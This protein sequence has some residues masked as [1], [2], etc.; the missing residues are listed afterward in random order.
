M[1]AKHTPAPWV[2][3]FRESHWSVWGDG[4]LIGTVATDDDV[5][6]VLAAPQLLEALENLSNAVTAARKAED[7][8]TKACNGEPDEAWHVAAAA[9]EDAEATVVICQNAALALLRAARG[10]EAN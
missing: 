9:C 6:L 2:G 10:Q 5:H 1:N 4:R 8:Y 7:A 3:H